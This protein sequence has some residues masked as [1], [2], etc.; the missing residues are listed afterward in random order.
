MSQEKFP[1]RIR[2]EY[3]EA[4]GMQ[5]KYAH[6]VWGG[7]NAQG[8]VEISFYSEC[9]KLPQYSERV[10]EPDGTFGPETAPL[11]ESLKI[12]TRHILAKIIVN[13]HTARDIMEWLDDK[14]Q[15]LDMDGD[16]APYPFD[17]SEPDREQ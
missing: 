17:G 12:V 15:I 13:Y 1:L 5:P 6:G 8:E 16:G 11:D 4:P 3:E 9:D 2:Y 7:I 14:I 10:V